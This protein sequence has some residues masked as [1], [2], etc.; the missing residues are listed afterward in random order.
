MSQV[1]YGIRKHILINTASYELGIFPL[2]SPLSISG[3]NNVGKSTAIFALQFPFLCSL[4]DMKF[5]KSLQETRQYYFPYENSY[6][7]TEIST[8]A[9]YF[10]V[11]A[12]GGGPVS[13]FEHQL[14]AY[15][16]QFDINDFR[17]PVSERTV[18]IRTL[19]ELSEHMVKTRNIWIKQ[20]KPHQ[21]RDALMGKM[22]ELDGG[23]SF[24][25]GMFRLKSMKDDNYRL[26]MRVFK[27]LL[28]LSD[29]NLDEIKHLLIDILMQGRKHN[30][31]DIM[32]R[33]RILSVG[34]D[35]ARARLVTASAIR[36][37]VLDLQSLKQSHDDSAW[38]CATLYPKI[39][40][41]F[42]ADIEQKA[43]QIADM[44]AQQDEVEPR[45]QA[46]K[47]SIA[48]LN[49][50]IQRIAI[51]RNDHEKFLQ[52]I[53]DAEQRFA[54]FPS[55]E[56]LDAELNTLNGRLE[57]LIGDLS[58]TQALDEA[59]VARDISTTERELLKLDRRIASISSNL[60]FH[61][62]EHFSEKSLGL[63]A[64]LFN[65][66]AL[67]SVAM[68]GQASQIL[69]IDALIA[70]LKQVLGHIKDGVYDDGA[71]RLDLSA[72]QDVN[73]SDYTDYDLI[74]A[75]RDRLSGRLESYRKDLEVARDRQALLS[76][77]QALVEE[78]AQMKSDIDAVSRYH[79]DKA[80]E[81]AIREALAQVCA[82]MDDLQASLSQAVEERGQLANRGAELDHAIASTRAAQSRLREK[83][84]QIKPVT[85]PDDLPER[86]QHRLPSALE[87]MIDAYLRAFA[88]LPV[89][90]REMR[91][92]RAVIEGKGGN[93]F[94]TGGGEDVRE[95]LA[96]IDNIDAFES[97]YEK[98]KNA[99]GGEMGAMFK[100]ITDNFHEFE[101]SLKAFNRTMNAQKVSNL[102]NI[103][104][105][106]DNQNAIWQAIERVTESNTLLADPE[107]IKK[108]ITHIDSLVKEKGVKLTLDGLFSLG[109]RIELENGKVIEQFNEAQ[110]EST[111]TGLTVKILLNVIM[112]NHLMLKRE[113]EI[114]NI[115]IYID[116]AQRIDPKNQQTLIRQ[117]MESGFVPVLASV[118][119]QPSAQYSIMLEHD[120]SGRIYVDEANWVRVEPREDDDLHAA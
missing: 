77:K 15:Q 12:C 97:A 91:G 94:L 106:A 10:V 82:Q 116:E 103:E 37:D 90:E 3:A 38:V 89:K 60:A 19:K 92:L 36:Q 81:P 61:L 87:D 69:D 96:A 41:G 34:M 63:I 114:V 99:F 11:G 50:S 35:Q 93:V 51:E 101:H 28:H 76:Q 43:R 110:I 31:S 74:A 40:K 88:D 9:G 49:Q 24:T 27:Q 117:C 55:P 22:I 33:Y 84:G 113:G 109:L 45:I 108:A 30:E 59:A 112:L 111:G 75:E 8:S 64:K 79:A 2:D 52:A 70:R 68:D 118:S 66:D 62:S 18:G 32:G 26:F 29:V 102:K 21:M 16:G 78:I 48:T 4:N 54:L 104:F 17:V 83:F 95:W 105:I 120:P 115:P 42:E 25:I 85:L 80:R 119:P 72:M 57:R 14:F 56:A 13:G 1:F 67:F 46:V 71:V 100:Q 6:V 7:L 98:E 5:P 73:L 23:E 107:K 86:V 58:R 47:D 39:V 20:L 44:L 65:H 53:N